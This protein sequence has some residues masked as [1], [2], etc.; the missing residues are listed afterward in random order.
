MVEIQASVGQQQ[1]QQQQQ[2]QSRHHQ[3]DAVADV[4]GGV[5]GGHGGHGGGVAGGAMSPRERGGTRIL[6]QDEVN[7]VAGALTFADKRVEE[8]TD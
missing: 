1:Q 4:E 5:H 3:S 7:I 8:V 6:L 2:Q